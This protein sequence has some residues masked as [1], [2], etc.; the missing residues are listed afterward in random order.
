M[1]NYKINYVSTPLWVDTILPQRPHWYDIVPHPVWDLPT[2]QSITQSWKL[3]HNHPTLRNLWYHHWR[4]RNTFDRYSETEI[5]L[6]LQSPLPC[7][8]KITPSQP[9]LELST[10]PNLRHILLLHRPPNQLN[11]SISQRLHSP[12]LPQITWKRII[13]KKEVIWITWK[14]I[15]NYEK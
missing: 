8:P 9:S 14:R 1:F 10:H 4:F 5:M 13:N 15:I 2:T 6:R 3:H 7:T 11:P 12:P